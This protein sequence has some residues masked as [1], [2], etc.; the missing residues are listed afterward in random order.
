M[1]AEAEVEY[2][3]GYP[4]LVNDAGSVDLIGRTAAEVVGPSAG[5]PHEQQMGGEDFAYLTQRV[6]GAMFYL[7]VRHPSWDAPKTTHTSS[8]D[9]DE[10]AL[11]IGAAM[12]AGTAMRFLEGR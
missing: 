6:P 8:F 4:A 5:V 10:D 12:L 1:R 3:Q 9:L 2:L 7:G 11:P